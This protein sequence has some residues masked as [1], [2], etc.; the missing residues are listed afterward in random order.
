MAGENR[1]TETTL[2]GVRSLPEN[3]DADAL[4]GSLA[5]GWGFEVEAADYAPVG[6]GS[7]HWVVSD[8]DGMRGFVTVDDLDRKTWL[9]NTRESVFDGLRRAF[10]TA[11]ALRDSG[12]D[13]VVAPTPA[14]SASL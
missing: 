5:D 6:G 3:F 10:D 11:L 8:L 2:R 12:L 14:S 9:G 4:T 1:Q 7:Y 13:F